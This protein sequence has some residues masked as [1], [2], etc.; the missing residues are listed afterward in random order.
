VKLR[1]GRCCFLREWPGADGA[2]SVRCEECCHGV[3]VL[4]FARVGSDL[5]DEV[6]VLSAHRPP[7]KRAA[8]ALGGYKSFEF[9]GAGRVHAP[10][11]L[12]PIT[13]PLRAWLRR[14][15]KRLPAPYARCS[16]GTVQGA[17]KRQLKQR[18]DITTAHEN[19]IAGADIRHAC[20]SGVRPRRELSSWLSIFLEE[21]RRAQA[22]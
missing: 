18:C 8:L 12:L 20:P 1:R 19:S 22:I 7:H 3:Q 9:A 2:V 21:A 5:N 16:I 13:A 6:G 17:R 11:D 15:G 10:P 4:G 14:R